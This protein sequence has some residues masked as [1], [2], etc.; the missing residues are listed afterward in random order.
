MLTFYMNR[1]IKV[2]SSTSYVVEIILEAFSKII[3]MR[4]DQNS[5]EDLFSG[6]IVCQPDLC[7]NTF[8]ILEFEYSKSYNFHSIEYLSA[9]SDLVSEKKLKSNVIRGQLRNKSILTLKILL[10]RVFPVR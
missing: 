8:S 4:T 5:S 3:Q 10:F 9:G 2:I 1:L 6:P 7:Q